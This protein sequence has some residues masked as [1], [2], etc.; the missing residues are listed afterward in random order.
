MAGLVSDSYRLIPRIRPKPRPALRIT[1]ALTR[2]ILLGV[3]LLSAAEL[4]PGTLQGWNSYV[5]TVNASMEQRANGSHPFL[6]V[7][8]SPDLKKLVLAGEAVVE[9]H[10]HD[11]IPSGLIHHWVGAMF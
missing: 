9:S 4:K 5:R 11:K 7:D 3:T 1:S 2:L 8:E 10:P 6:W